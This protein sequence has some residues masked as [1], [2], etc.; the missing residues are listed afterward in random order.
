MTEI[1]Y[2]EKYLDNLGNYRRLYSGWI[3]FTRYVKLVASISGAGYLFYEGHTVLGSMLLL[4]AGA[5][6]LHSSSIQERES[7][8]E[9]AI[10]ALKVSRDRERKDLDDLEKAAL[11]SCF[12]FILESRF[13]ALKSKA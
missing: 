9:G 10:R 11:V 7:Y 6:A 4:Y 8:L 5:D 2:D 3:T 12:P 13:D 1:N